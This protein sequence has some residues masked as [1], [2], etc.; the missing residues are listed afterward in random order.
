MSDWQIAKLQNRC[1]S[2]GSQMTEGQEIRSALFDTG[3][4]FLRRD[5]CMAC[6][7]KGEPEGTFS[8]WKTKVPPKGEARPL[9]GDDVLRDMFARLENA[10]DDHK[11]RFRYV[12]AL[13]LTR[14]KIFK[15]KHIEREEGRSWLVLSDRDTDQSIRVLDPQMSEQ[16]IA[17]LSEEMGQVFAPKP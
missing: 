4:E 1:A 16:E 13:L 8:S 7:A 9:A 15:F 5:Y 10:A 6:W 17:A 11:L 2:C 14:R 3:T 12:L